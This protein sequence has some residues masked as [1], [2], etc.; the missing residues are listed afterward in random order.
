MPHPLEH[1]SA[2]R[3]LEAGEAELLAE[4]MQA[5]AA[6]SRIRLLYALVGGEQSVGALAESTGGSPSAVSQQLRVLRHLRL[7]ATRRDGRGVLYRLHDDHVVELLAAVRHHTEHA[8]HA[9]TDPATAMR[10]REA[11]TTDTV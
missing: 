4:S 10:D 7:V 6:P 2:Q 5:F 9:W 1:S 3:P 8:H 11:A